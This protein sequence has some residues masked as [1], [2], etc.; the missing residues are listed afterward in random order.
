MLLTCLTGC[1][2]PAKPPLEPIAMQ[3][4]IGIVNANNARITSCLKASGWLNIQFTD[5]RGRHRYFD[6][7]QSSFHVIAP[8]HTYLSAK[9]GLGTEELRLGSN[10]EDY[11]FYIKQDDNTYRHGTYAALTGEA[12]TSMPLRSD[13]V[14]EALGINSLPGDTYGPEGPVQRIVDEFQQLIF[15]AYTPDDQG[16][17]RKEYWLDRYEP[18]LVRRI[19]YRDDLGR[20]LMDSRLSDHKPAYRDGPHLP[21]RVLVSW[22]HNDLKMDFRIRRWEAKPG[23]GRDHRAFV[24]PHKSEDP[25]KDRFRNIIDLDTEAQRNGR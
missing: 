17:I 13:L 24:A 23:R 2:P 11:W 3:D 20:V 5:D 8:R 10:D 21:G 7:P 1:P 6:L 18:R 9:S 12:L 4:A 19:L 14:I 15:L 25:F 22:L 16:V